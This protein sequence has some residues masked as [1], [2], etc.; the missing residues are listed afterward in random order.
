MGQVAV[1][2]SSP[3]PLHPTILLPISWQDPLALVTFTS[4]PQNPARVREQ[5]AV[6]G[7]TSAFLVGLLLLVWS[8]K[9]WSE[10]P[11]FAVKQKPTVVAL[12]CSVPLGSQAVQEVSGGAQD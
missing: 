11:I 7:L 10:T 3:C 9:G 8:L 1:T 4:G 12:T 6:S 2:S 5:V